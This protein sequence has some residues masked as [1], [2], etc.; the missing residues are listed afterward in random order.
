MET[1]P[2]TD[3]GAGYDSSTS[4]PPPEKASV[5]EDFLD[6]FHSP[7]SVFARRANSGY[8]LQLLIVSV[9]AAA[10]AFSQRSVLSQIFDVEFARGTAKAMAN[11]PRITQEMIN[12]G[13]P[14]QEAIATFAGYIGTPIF[15]FILAFFV[16]IVAKLFSAKVTYGQAAMIT[17]IAW[18]PRLL[19][20]L[21]TT[22]QSVLMDTSTVTSMFSLSLSPARFMDPDTT[23]PKLF[24]LMGSLEIFS[25]WFW[26]L[27]AIG[28]S[29]VAKVPRARGYAAAVVLFILGTLPLMFR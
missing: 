26:I 7:S 19:G 27:V 20:S 22:V 17:T 10:F 28:L 8:G 9:L 12:Q 13:R 14:I 29:V 3:R 6:V 4:S 16:W 18:I 1:R 2:G 11:N 21:I 24:G 5:V 15:I 23:N 25:I